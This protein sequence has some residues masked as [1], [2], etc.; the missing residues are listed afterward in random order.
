[1]DLILWRHA[2]AELGEPDEGRALTPKGHKQAAK[3]AE[4]LDRN[5][6]ESCRILVSPAT[7]TLQTVEALKRKYKVVAD[8]APSMSA[9][10][11]LRAANWPDSREPVLI[12]GHQPT[13]GQVA[14][15]L[16]S[17]QPQEW[18][19]RKGNVWWIAQRE[20]GDITTNYLKAVVAPEFLA[21]SGKHA[22]R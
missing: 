22:P 18:S 10:D 14:A 19:L 11:L 7:R 9:D 6:P 2:E 16:I 13:L 21:S 5:L 8:L 4:W 17:G 12:V 3:M 20:R 15:R 1:M